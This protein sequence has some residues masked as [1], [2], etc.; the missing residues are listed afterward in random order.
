MTGLTFMAMA[1]SLFVVASA[2][3]ITMDRIVEDR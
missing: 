3:A 1:I 2:I